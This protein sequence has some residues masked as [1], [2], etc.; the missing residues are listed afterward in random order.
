[1][2]SSDILSA[3]LSND[4]NVRKEAEAYM[5]SFAQQDPKASFDM[6]LAALDI[7]QNQVKSPPLLNYQLAELAAVSLKKYH[8][9][10]SEDFSK[11]D[12]QRI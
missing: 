5:V 1:M 4:N 7:N 3:F 2:N 9:Q 11:M 8:L 12:D 6:Y 10:N